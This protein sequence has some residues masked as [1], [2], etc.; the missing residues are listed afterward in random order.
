MNCLTAHI[1]T[2]DGI[3]KE[4]CKRATDILDKLNINYEIHVNPVVSNKVKGCFD[5]HMAI[6]KHALK[7]NDEYIFIVEDNIDL[8]PNV[9]LETF[10]NNIKT[11]LE[12]PY[13][14]TFYVFYIGAFFLPYTTSKR[15]RSTEYSDIMETFGMH[16]TSA[17]IIHKRFYIQLLELKDTDIEIDTLIEKYNN[18]YIAKRSLFYRYS[19]LPSIVNS[20]LDSIRK[21]YFSPLMYKTSEYLYNQQMYSYEYII[22]LVIIIIA[23]LLFIIYKFIRY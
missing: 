22:L 16:G 9:N 13:R 10:N 1:I 19:K 4:R 12:G 18:R 8:S 11:F 3:G 14:D 7:N 5:S 20:N 6:Y 2:V 23:L 15:P 17:Y 21:Y